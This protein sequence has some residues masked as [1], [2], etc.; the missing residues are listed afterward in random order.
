MNSAFTILKLFVVSVFV[1]TVPLSAIA[2]QGAIGE[3]SSVT[4]EYTLTLADG[5]M[6]GSNVGKEPLVYQQGQKQILPALEAALTGMSAGEEKRVELGADDAY[7]QVQA[8][9]FREVPLEELPEDAHQVGALLSLQGRPGAIRVH[10]IREQV[11]I[12]DFN[13]PLAGKDLT[14]DIRVIAV[15]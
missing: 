1:T 10:E 12:L 4:L 5:S 3:G 15:E 13:H 11:A 9:A 6:V 2:Q 14:F 7:G 8:D